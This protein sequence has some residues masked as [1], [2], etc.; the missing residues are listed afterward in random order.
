ML[1]LVQ[2]RQSL[3]ACDLTLAYGASTTLSNGTY[4]YCSMTVSAGATLY[5]G[6]AVTVNMTGDVD[7]EGVVSGV[8]LGYGS[9]F[10]T[11]PGPGAGGA[12]TT[13]DG[14]AGGGHGGDGG[15]GMISCW[16]GT[17]YSPAGCST[18]T[19][20][21]LGGLAYD[22]LYDPS[23]MGSAG[24]P[25]GGSTFVPGGAGGAAFTLSAPANNVTINGT[26]DMSG[27]SPTVTGVQPEAG[28]GAGGTVYIDAQNILGMGIIKALGGIGGAAWSGGAG[29]GGGGG[30]L[31]L[32]LTGGMP[33]S[34]DGLVNVHSGP[35]GM[36]GEICGLACTSWTGGP[37]QDGTYYNC[38]PTATPTIPLTFTPTDTPTPSNTPTVTST[39]TPSETPTYTPTNT[40]TPLPCPPGYT[41]P[42]PPGPGECFTYPAP[43]FGSVVHFVY[44]MREPGTVRVLVRNERADLVAQISQTQGCGV[45]ESTLELDRFAAGV[46]FY[47]VRITYDSGGQEKLKL[48]KFLV[49]R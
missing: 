37:G 9:S 14:G 27:A 19:G 25:S 41:G 49:Q 32:C 35:G 42:Q 46:Y 17:M 36:G 13:V 48:D 10:N 2:P 45:Q 33:S 34:F 29:A 30:R 21:A 43:A 39:G 31:R 44:Y 3:A 7:I 38:A 28:G 23:W 24:G 40:P 18:M 5:I 6:G 1:V 16:S 20:P 12:G 22:S 47:Q 11:S 26:I 8:G 4:T 15:S